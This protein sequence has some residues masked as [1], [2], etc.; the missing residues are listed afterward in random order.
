MSDHGLR[1]KGRP[2][3]N[4]GRA[5]VQARPGQ[6]EFSKAT[7]KKENLV[8]PKQDAGYQRLLEAYNATNDMKLKETLWELLRK[9]RAQIMPPKP[10]SEPAQV[11]TIWDIIKRER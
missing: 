4:F 1:T 6:I 10:P 3:G 9:R 2:T 5:R 11:E 7:L 8:I